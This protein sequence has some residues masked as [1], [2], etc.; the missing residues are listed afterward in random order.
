MNKKLSHVIQMLKA[1]K[2]MFKSSDVGIAE[3]VNVYSLKTL[4]LNLF[5]AQSY[6]ELR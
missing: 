1:T 4:L 5:H 6:K 3:W 2:D